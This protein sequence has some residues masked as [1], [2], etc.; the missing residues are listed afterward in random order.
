[1]GLIVWVTSLRRDAA[2]VCR[3][4]PILVQ[5]AA[6][7]CLSD[8]ATVTTHQ[9]DTLSVVLRPETSDGNQPVGFAGELL[10]VRTIMDLSLKSLQEAVAIREQI[11]ALKK[12]LA[13]LFQRTTP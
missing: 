6:G 4:P 3:G 11:N 7:V 12:R 9:T 8:A 13:S 5:S 2:K 10:S 1:M